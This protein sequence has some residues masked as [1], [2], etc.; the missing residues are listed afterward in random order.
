[1]PGAGTRARLDRVRL[2]RGKMPTCRI[3]AKDEHAVETLVRHQHMASGWVEHH[4]MGVRDRLLGLVRPGLA[5]QHHELMLVL[6]SSVRRKRKHRDATAAI[7]GD[8][9]ELAAGIDG[10]MNA[11]LSSGRA[12]ADQFGVS[13]L[14]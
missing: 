3:E 13:G 1:M 12:A 5:R 14:S 6:E 11:V 8:D 4:V 10:L 9:H 7:V 2:A